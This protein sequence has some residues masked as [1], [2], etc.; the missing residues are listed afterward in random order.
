MVFVVHL[1][2]INHIYYDQFSMGPSGRVKKLWMSLNILVSD[3]ECILVLSILILLIVSMF[4]G[5][6][7][8][9]VDQPQPNIEPVKNEPAS[10]MPTRNKLKLRKM[11]H[12]RRLCHKSRSHIL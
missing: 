4:I 2:P 12:R 8:Y 5:T 6:E 1:F 10:V 11:L 3:S 9:G 7:G